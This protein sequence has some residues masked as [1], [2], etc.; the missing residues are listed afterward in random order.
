[1]GNITQQYIARVAEELMEKYPED[2]GSD[3]KANKEKVIEYCTLN[4][5][6]TRNKI[7]GFI[8]HRLKQD[9]KEE[10]AAS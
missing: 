4:S 7:A 9:K 2:F 6:G 10:K 8:T 1:M 5:K 3:F